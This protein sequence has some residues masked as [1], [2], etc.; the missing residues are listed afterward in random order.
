[1]TTP[2]ETQRADRR[3]STSRPIHDLLAERWS[4]RSYEPDHQVAEEELTTLLE[5]ARWAPSAQNRQPRRFIA[6]RRGTRLYERLASTAN[7]RNQVWAPRSSAL[8][9]GIVERT[10]ADGSNQRFGEYDLGQSIAHLSIQAQHLGLQVRQMGGFHAELAASEFGL[11]PPLVPFILVAVG[12]ATPVE[13]LE[14][15]FVERDTAPRERLPLDQV[16]LDRS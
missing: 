11:R 6:G 14:S 12:R 9:L 3:A 8:V 1:M 16:V 10:A 7:E 4:P 5:A 13:A 2:T 15:E